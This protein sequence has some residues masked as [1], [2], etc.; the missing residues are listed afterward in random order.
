[1][2]NVE[3]DIVKHLDYSLSGQ[4]LAYITTASETETK[5]TGWI[6]TEEATFESF[7]FD[8]FN[9]T[10]TNKTENEVRKDLKDVDVLFVAGGNPFY[11]LLQIQK[12]NFT[13]IAHEHINA[14]KVYIG[15]SSGSL[16]A[17][18]DIKIA[19][20]EEALEK[21]PELTDFRGMGLVDFTVFP[22]WGKEIARDFYLKRRMERAYGTDNKIILL[23]DKQ[24][25]SVKDDWYQIVAV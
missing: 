11:L 14:G 16:T 22:H 12:C 24:Y 6:K 20:R 2:K 7:G 13:A 17:G 5:D 9:Y 21:V 8:V 18:P 10:I 25:V 3:S 19:I 1:M 15:E 4:M 23:T